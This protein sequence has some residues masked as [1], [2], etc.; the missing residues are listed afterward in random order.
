MDEE[1]DRMWRDSM[2]PDQ[3]LVLEMAEDALGRFHTQREE[4]VQRLERKWQSASAEEAANFSKVVM[5]EEQNFMN[6][7]RPVRNMIADL[8]RM[9]PPKP[10]VVDARQVSAEFLKQSGCVY[11]FAAYR[12]RH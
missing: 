11:S 4:L 6:S 10:F 8:F 1:I 5:E 7:T 9:L 3:R 2:S 12:M